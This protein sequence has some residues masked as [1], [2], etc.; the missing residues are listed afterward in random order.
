MASCRFLHV[1]RDR[2][3]ATW[4]GVAGCPLLP[5]HPLLL[6]VCHRHHGHAPA[7]RETGCGRQSEKLMSRIFCWRFERW[8]LTGSNK[9]IFNKIIFLKIRQTFFTIFPHIVFLFIL[10][11]CLFPCRL[12]SSSSSNRWW[13]SLQLSSGWTLATLSW[14]SQPCTRPGSPS[15]APSGWLPEA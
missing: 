6:T 3:P 10:V 11:E 8:F 9:I 5:P 15:W 4:W 13:S 12:Q 2:T 7:L 1:H 14:P